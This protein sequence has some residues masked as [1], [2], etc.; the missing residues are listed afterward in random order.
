MAAR[1]KAG[2]RKSNKRRSLAPRAGARGPEPLETPLVLEDRAVAPLVECVRVLG[3]A[4]LAAY[5]EP[6]GSSPVLLAMVP[7]DGVEPTP[8]Q[9]DLSPA[10]VQRL[11]AKIDEVGAFLDPLIA[12]RAPDG[13]LWT[14][15]GR[16]RLAAARI[17]GLRAI[18]VL[19]CADEALAYRI[20]ALNTE[21]AHNLRDRSLEAIRMAR[22]LAKARPRARESDHAAELES[23]ALLTLGAVYERDKRFAGGAYHPLLRRVDAFGTKPLA[24]SLAERDGW[25]ARLLEIDARVR[26]LIAALPGAR[27]PLALPAQLRGGAHRSRAAGRAR[28]GREAAEHDAARRAHAPGRERAAVRSRER[29][30]ARPGPGGCGRVGSRTAVTAALHQARNQFQRPHSPVR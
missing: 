3:G 13:T 25:A 4:A 7:T 14:P 30:R 21:K 10:H 1:K 29:A 5:R 18:S 12:V 15:N 9:R 11:A 26:E 16:H 24:R 27:L 20:L 2:R 19:L 8:F 22:A 28:P 6:C 23:P 17:L